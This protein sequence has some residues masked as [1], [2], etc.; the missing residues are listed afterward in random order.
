MSIPVRLNKVL[1]SLPQGVR[2][3]AVSKYHPVEMLREAYDAG[4]RIFAE[5]H[6]Q[7][8][9]AKSALLPSDIEWHMIGHLQTNKVRAAVSVVSVIESVDSRRLLEF[10]NKE[11]QRAGRTVDCLLEVHVAAEQTKT[12]WNEQDLIQY[13]DS[14]EWR[15]LENIRLRGVMGMATNTD[16]EDIIRNDFCHLQRIFQTLQA[17]V[18]PEFRELSMGMSDDYPIAVECGATLVRVGSYIFGPRVY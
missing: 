14:D 12:G 4:Q 18:G 2:L 16:S 6:V 13:I 11:A 7:E 3:A 10:I 17:K 8:M 5:N 9:V 15:N 1:Q